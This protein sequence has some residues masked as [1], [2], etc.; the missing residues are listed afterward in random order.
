MLHI[1]DSVLAFESCK[2][3]TS[4]KTSAGLELGPPANKLGLRGSVNSNAALSGGD[5]S[6]RNP[7]PPDRKERPQ[8][9]NR[10]RKRKNNNHQWEEEIVQKTFG[11]KEQEEAKNKHERRD[12]RRKRQIQ[13]REKALSKQQGLEGGEEAAFDPNEQQEV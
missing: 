12:R 1:K 2:L 8:R 5:P 3:I 10:D 7:P 6:V 13:L 4:G 9:E 11:G